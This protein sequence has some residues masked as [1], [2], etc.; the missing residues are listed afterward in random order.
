[1]FSPALKHPDIAYDGSKA[2]YVDSSFRHHYK[3]RPEIRVPPPPPVHST[4]F[5][6]YLSLRE[7]RHTQIAEETDAIKLA[8]DEE[9]DP[10]TPT[11]QG[12]PFATG[13]AVAEILHEM[14][15]DP[16]ARHYLLAPVGTE[17][18]AEE[19]ADFLDGDTMA[20]AKTL[21]HLKSQSLTPPH[22][23]QPPLKRSKTLN[24]HRTPLAVVES[25]D[26]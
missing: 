12:R 10:A 6:E 14:E 1:M 4:F 8:N 18:E 21:S 23:D 17:D 3:L 20:A 22:C 19:D 16:D 2:V 9:R 15:A 13:D 26:E 5:R 24:P 11:A 7:L 25:M